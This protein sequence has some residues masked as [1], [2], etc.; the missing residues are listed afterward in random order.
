MSIQW[1]TPEGL[2]KGWERVLEN[3]GCA[4]VDGVTVERFAGRVDVELDALLSRVERGE[5]RALPLL[6]IVVQ[7]KPSSAATRTLLVPAVRDRV[8]QT[9]VGRHL[10]RAFEDEFLDCSFAFRPHRS[11]NSAIARIRFLHDHGFKYVAETDIDSF[12]D[13]VDHTL[14]RERLRSRV[15]DDGLRDLLDGWIGGFC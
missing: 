6:P 8:L 1:L 12:F 14:L 4:G 9:A 7:K 5:Y 3:H 11:V 10:G 15:P 13:R 2:L